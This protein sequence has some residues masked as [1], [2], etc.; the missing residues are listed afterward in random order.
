MIKNIFDCVLYTG[1]I[2]NVKVHFS[3]LLSIQHLLIAC[4][5]I[6]AR[7]YVFIPFFDYI[8]L[9][10]AHYRC[11]KNKEWSEKNN[12]RVSIVIIPDKN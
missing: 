5:F 4:L 10:V 1:Q 3:A 8:K 9:N 11:V 7:L 2:S 12:P 6:D